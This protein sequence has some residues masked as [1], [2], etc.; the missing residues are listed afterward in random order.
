[1]GLAGS[2]YGAASVGLSTTFLI[3]AALV[4]MN[5]TADPK[6]MGPEKRLFTF[7]I[8]YLFGLFAALV[9]DKWVLA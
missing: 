8:V 5:R 2:I 1:M 6:W 9:A 4:V 7:S 3:L